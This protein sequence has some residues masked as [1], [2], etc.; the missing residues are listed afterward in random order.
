M[1]SKAR[2]LLEKLYPSE[3][4]SIT[5]SKF[6]FYIL[7]L[8]VALGVV[9]LYMR[10][11]NIDELAL[12][13]EKHAE[14]QII[15]RDYLSSMSRVDNNSEQFNRLKREVANYQ[16]ELI[17]IEEKISNLKKFWFLE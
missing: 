5:L 6:K 4:I 11:Q 9:Y 3:P 12:L 1:N 7:L 13:K 10:S 16:K 2:E 15:V 8:F 17:T 14:V